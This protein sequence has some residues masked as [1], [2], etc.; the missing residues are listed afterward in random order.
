MQI[1]ISY[2]YYMYLGLKQERAT[3]AKTV[4]SPQRMNRI[5]PPGNLCESRL[6]AVGR[7]SKRRTNPGRLVPRLRLLCTHFKH[8]NRVRICN[9]WYGVK[10]RKVPTC[11]IHFL[12]ST[13]TSESTNHQK[14][15]VDV[16]SSAPRSGLYT[17]S[18]PSPSFSLYFFGTCF[19]SRRVP[20]LP[21]G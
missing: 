20:H 13:E 2:Y 19:I 21:N 16:S 12:A 3:A 14:Y 8:Q 6:G 11:Q 1:S 18:L 15:Q 10:K 4:L 5:D 17:V 9:S 7:E